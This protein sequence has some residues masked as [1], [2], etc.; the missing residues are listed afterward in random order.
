MVEKEEKF[1]V[2]N[3]K[4]LIW[5][6]E[7]QKNILADISKAIME[8]RSRRGANPFP[9]YIVCNQDEKYAEKIWQIILDEEKAKE[10]VAA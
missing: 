4:D 10:E 8:G 9:K 7:D 2:I 1:F 3:K 6:T 5:L